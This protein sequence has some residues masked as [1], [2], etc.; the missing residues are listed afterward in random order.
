M[1]IYCNSYW[2]DD[3]AYLMESLLAIISSNVNVACCMLKRRCL[4]R[5]F[6]LEYFM[7]FRRF[8]RTRL[9]SKCNGKTGPGNRMIVYHRP[10]SP[11]AVELRFVMGCFKT[12]K[13]CLIICDASLI[14]SVRNLQAFCM[15]M[16]A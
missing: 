9:N 16:S 10:Q 13:C 11:M 6:G 3:S 7:D 14:R 5:Y 15:C 12:D 4:L 2:P 8:G 1:S